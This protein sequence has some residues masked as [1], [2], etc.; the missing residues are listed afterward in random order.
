[1]RIRASGWAFAVS[2]ALGL[3]A[4]WNTGAN[5]LY[6]VVGGL[7][8]VVL[9]SLIIPP[10]NLRRLRVTRRAPEAAHRGEPFGVTIRIDNAKRIMPS[11]AVRIERTEAPG[12]TAA[13]ALFIPARHGIILRSS[14]TL[15]R[16]GVHRLEPI[17]VRSGFPFGLV[18]WQ[19]TIRDHVEVVV[20]PR[21]K[22]VRTAWI[23]HLRGARAMPRVFRGEGDEFFS[24]REYM[25][26]D[27]VRHIAWRASA[28]KGALL[29]REMA[30]E[31]SRFVVFVLDTYRPPDV[32][33][34]DDRFE[35][36]VEMVASLAVALLNR[37]Y[38]VSIIT[39]LCRLPGSEGKSQVRQVLEMLARVEASDD[40]AHGG[41]GWF[42]HGDE[43]GR[44][45]YA[46]IAAD[47]REW[48]RRLPFAGSRVADLREVARA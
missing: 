32:A 3:L 45:A 7:G 28:K 11:G 5:L 18:E 20:Y 24:L 6:L 2:F 40:P 17:A 19:R 33:D 47:P 46:F 30:R 1:M 23:E 9:V 36:A 42:S 41:F 15:H 10:W 13:M 16:R 14:Q 31:S 39:P 43:W 34:F 22:S 8:A 38:V 21:V 44:A 27:D 35:E 29:I 25:P 12:G 48:G 4:A 37:Q 26:G